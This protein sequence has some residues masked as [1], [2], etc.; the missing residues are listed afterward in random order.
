MQ[1]T[2]PLHSLYIEIN[3]VSKE[4]NSRIVYR[5]QNTEDSDDLLYGEM[6][7]MERQREGFVVGDFNNLSIHRLT[8]EGDQEGS[9]LARLVEDSFLHQIV[10][11]QNRGNN[12]LNLVLTIDKTV[13]HS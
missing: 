5:P 4:V 11:K 13:L 7:D 9:R 1:N 3:I 8:L 2:K 10:H 12:F 6:I